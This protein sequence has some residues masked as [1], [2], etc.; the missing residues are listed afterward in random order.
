MD[1]EAMQEQT[2]T[3]TRTGEIILLDE[4]FDII[5]EFPPLDDFV[6]LSRLG[7]ASDARDLFNKDLR[8]QLDDHFPVLAEFAD[9]LLEDEKYDEL[10]QFL[11]RETS[12]VDGSFTEDELEQLSL[13]KA[14]SD[15]EMEEISSLEMSN[16]DDEARPVSREK[17]LHA[18]ALAR[19]W[20]IKKRTVVQDGDMDEVEQQQQQQ[21]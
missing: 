2:Q 15:A 6:F 14:F 8:S 11:E 16:S 9:M 20:H 5:E 13:M 1:P 4:E 10:S 19:S 12:K 18:F 21:Q 17:L 7:L 3:E